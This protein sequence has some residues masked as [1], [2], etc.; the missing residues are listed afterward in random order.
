M[1]CNK[2]VSCALTETAL[3]VRIYLSVYGVHG[4]GFRVRMRAVVM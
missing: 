4:A 3:S 1:R 2:Q